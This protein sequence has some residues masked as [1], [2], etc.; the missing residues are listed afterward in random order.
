MKKIRLGIIGLGRAGYG[1][2]TAELRGKEELFEI[3]AVCDV[4]RDRC[5]NMQKL[6]GASIR[7]L[8]L[9]PFDVSSTQI[10]QSLKNRED[11]SDLLDCRVYSYIL[12]RG[13]YL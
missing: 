4:E 7:I 1:M 11:V 3:A 2:H 10:R 8:N 12:E 6:Y 9:K 13:L 5:E